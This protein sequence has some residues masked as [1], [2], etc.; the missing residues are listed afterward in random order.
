MQWHVLLALTALVWGLGM[1]DLGAWGTRWG[2]RYEQGRSVKLMTCLMN[3][4]ARCRSVCTWWPAAR[5]FTVSFSEMIM[6]LGDSWFALT[7]RE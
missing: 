5:G 4:F 7:G 3:V 2:W 6:K 1:G